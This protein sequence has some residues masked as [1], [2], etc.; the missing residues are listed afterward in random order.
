M[1][2]PK[3][4]NIIASGITRRVDHKNPAVR[5]EDEFDAFSVG[6][7]NYS[8]RRVSPYAIKYF[9]FGENALL[10]PIAFLVMEVL[11]LRAF[12]FVG[13]AFEIDDA[14]VFLEVTHDGERAVDAKVDIGFLSRLVEQRALLARRERVKETVA[15]GV[16]VQ[17]RAKFFGHWQAVLAGVDLQ[18]DVNMIAHLAGP[19]FLASAC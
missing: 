7:C 4:T 15:F 19:T 11:Q 6:T 5:A 1:P 2:S 12:Q 17:Y 13:E 10:L 8:C 9:A 3:A 16:L 14:V 18:P